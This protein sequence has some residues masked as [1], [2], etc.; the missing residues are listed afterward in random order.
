MQQQRNFLLFLILVG[1]VFTVYLPFRQ[2]MMQNG[3]EQEGETA[4]R[5][6]E[7]KKRPEIVSS[8]LPALPSPT[9]SEN[10]IALGEDNPESPFNLMVLFDPLGGGVRS[11]HLNKFRPADD[12][13]GKPAKGMGLELVPDAANL[14]LP[15]HLLYHFAPEDVDKDTTRPLDTLGRRPWTV[16]KTNGEAVQ[17]ITSE[18]GRP[19]KRVSFRT[20]VNG[21]IL[22][23]TYSLAEG[24]YHVGLSV[25][26]ERPEAAAGAKPADKEPIRFR[27][28][29]TGAKGLPIE[30]K[31]YTN[32]F[33]NAMIALEG[34]NQS[35]YR[36]FEDLRQI[37]LWGGGNPINKSEDRILRYAGV[38]VQYFASVIVVDDKQLEGQ[39][40]RFLRRASSSL[41]TAVIRGKVKPGS[42]GLTDRVVLL[43]DD[44]RTTSTFYLPPSAS[45]ELRLK[46]ELLRD[47]MLVSV[48]YQPLSYDEQLKECPRIVL[49]MRL[50]TDAL[51]MHSLWEDDI[52]VRVSTEPVTL[53]PGSWVTHR[54]LLYNGPVKPSLLGQL[55]GSSAV[56]PSLVSRYVDRLSLNTLTDYPSPGW[57][58]NFSGAIG[59]SWLVIR[60]TNLMHMVLGWIHLLLQNYGI[61]IIL[62][63]ILVRLIMFPLS[64]KQAM[65]GIKMQALQPE[66]KKLKE[67]HKDD[68]QAF[69]QA[70]MELF[71]RHGVNPI[72]SCW[73]VLLQM[74]I[75]M[76]LYFALQE[77][78]QFRLAPFWPTWISNLAAPDM[79][80]NWSR[81]I[82]MI[83]RDADYGGMLYLGPYFNLLPVIAIGLMVAQ[84]KM[85]M[86][87]A[88]DKDQEMQQKMM[89]IMMI[90]MGIFFYKIA[91]GLC[92]YIITSTLWG[93]AERKFL[94]KA[95]TG[96][97][98]GKPGEASA[99]EGK[100]GSL[101]SMMRS[102][103]SKT[104]PVPSSGPSS[105][106]GKKG[107]KGKRRPE[108]A[109]EKDE[110]PAT[111]VG[112]FRQRLSDWWNDVLEQARKK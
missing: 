79:L 57:M 60:C 49:D 84:Q 52:T 78:I 85:L 23:K 20:E 44:R 22:T 103:S 106:G 92:I 31:W 91:A 87:P 73:V 100:A 15:S 93:F 45:P 107:G 16:V 42:Q 66:L 102:D 98:P 13:S 110:V 105:V 80:I 56:D 53:A 10:L 41:E 34:R 51:A 109:R 18:N 72:G 59:W 112:G 3:N 108:R 6:P 11:I 36:E 55:R 90:V 21:L 43:S 104:G 28:Q 81:S 1:L 50:G 4:V 94:P 8:Q 76:G 19:E 39:D 48:L 111:G 63:T 77:S 69:A 99:T 82:P 26:I 35:I 74:P 68:N 38:A 83:S 37:S 65:M 95:S 12:E 47:D 29:L 14:H 75:M 32:T 9:N 96:T 17:T 62:L 88:A 58:G 30:G 97:G 70:Q 46:R 5:K 61:S 27:Y 101:L 71:R 89:R 54:Y 40:A 33:R 64:R 25:D 86:P 24:D 7:D 67:K 2:R